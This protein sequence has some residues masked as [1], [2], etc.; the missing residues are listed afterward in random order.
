MID[1]ETLDEIADQVILD[2]TT[3]VTLEWKSDKEA[4]RFMNFTPLF[5][6]SNYLYAL[7]HRRPN[8]DEDDEEDKE[9]GHQN[10]G[11]Q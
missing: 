4:N 2:K 8:R 6:D 1:P 3:Q 11:Q 10:E 9:E 7:S 5:T